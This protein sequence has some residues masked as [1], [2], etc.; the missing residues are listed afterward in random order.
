MYMRMRSEKRRTMQTTREVLP[1]VVITGLWPRDTDQ[2]SAQLQFTHSDLWNAYTTGVRKPGGAIFLW[3]F[4]GSITIGS[5]AIWLFYGEFLEVSY[6]IRTSSIIR[7]TGFLWK[8]HF[9]AFVEGPDKL[10]YRGRS[11]Q[12][13]RMCLNGDQPRNEPPTND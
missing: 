5:P 4:L 7:H 2:L 6:E 3:S 10:L 13:G 8:L 11:R 1:G 9:P 12:N